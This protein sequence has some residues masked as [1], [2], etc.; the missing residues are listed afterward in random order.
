MADKP[1]PNT[2]ILVDWSANGTYTLERNP[3]HAFQRVVELG[4]RRLE[5]VE[6]RDGLW[7]YR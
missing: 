3:G 6:D 2:H 7:A 5:H 1:T 4:G